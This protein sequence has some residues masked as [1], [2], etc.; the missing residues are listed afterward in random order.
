MALPIIV[1]GSVGMK[2]ISNQSALM[3]VEVDPSEID[4]EDITSSTET[5]TVGFLT[6]LFGTD[7]SDEVTENQNALA[8][9]DMLFI[10]IGLGALMIGIM[11]G[12]P[13]GPFHID[14]VD[15]AVMSA[16]KGDRLQR[17]QTSLIQTK[18]VQWTRARL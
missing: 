8:V 3:D 4:V 6:S 10:G 18:W 5:T 2:S 13:G 15:K 12:L 1:L 7:Y 11:I 9:T 17:Q 14:K 16:E